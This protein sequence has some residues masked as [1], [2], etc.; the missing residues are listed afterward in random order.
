MFPSTVSP[1]EEDFRECLPM[2]AELSTGLIKTVEGTD[3][4]GTGREKDKVL[5]NE[6]VSNK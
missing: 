1:S 5:K 4:C 6:R 2:D 3:V